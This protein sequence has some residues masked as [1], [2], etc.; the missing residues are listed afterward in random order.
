MI[1]LFYI[2]DEFYWESGTVMSSLYNVDTKER[3]DW[4]KVQLFIRSENN[5]VLIRPANEEEM[6]WAKNKLANIKIRRSCEEAGLAVKSLGDS[7]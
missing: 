2:G 6:K 5:E 4:G 1:K 3:W 7:F